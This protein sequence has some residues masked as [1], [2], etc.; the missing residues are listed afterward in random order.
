MQLQIENS[1]RY[2]LAAGHGHVCNLSMRSATC[3]A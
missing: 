1:K 3:Q 2:Q